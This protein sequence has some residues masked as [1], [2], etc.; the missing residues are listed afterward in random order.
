MINGC[1]YGEDWDELVKAV[2]QYKAYQDYLESGGRVRSVDDVLD[3]LAKKGEIAE[4]SDELHTKNVFEMSEDELMKDMALK[5]P[6]FETI[7]NPIELSDV[8][9]SNSKA[10]ATVDYLVRNLSGR[11]NVPYQMV[12]QEEAN[13]I[14][15]DAG[16]T[17]TGQ[18]GFYVGGIVYFIKDKLKIYLLDSPKI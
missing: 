11:L 7:Y 6:G 16:A 14:I 5:I 18:P 13:K 4:E 9:V 1:P 17:Y 3:K 12:T 8:A 15:S 2:G 10:N